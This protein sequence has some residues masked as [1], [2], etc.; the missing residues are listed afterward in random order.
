[1]VSAKCKRVYMSMVSA[2]YKRVYMSICVDIFFWI[3]TDMSVYICKY[4]SEIFTNG[5]AMFM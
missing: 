4:L 1:M 3:L 5:A 2:K